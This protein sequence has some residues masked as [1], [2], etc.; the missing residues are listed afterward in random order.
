MGRSPRLQDLFASLNIPLAITM[1]SP[2]YRKGFGAIN[3]IRH[4]VAI[5]SDSDEICDAQHLEQYKRRDPVYG[6]DEVVVP[7][8]LGH[9]GYH[10]SELIKKLIVAKM[11]RF[12][13]R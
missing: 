9:S 8:G 13:A 4:W 6:A 5:C 7:G 12:G 10:D 3:H 11:R 1:G 2:L